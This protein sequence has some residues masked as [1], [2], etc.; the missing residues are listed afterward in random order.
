MEAGITDHIWTIR[1]LLSY[2]RTRYVYPSSVGSMSQHNT[3]PTKCPVCGSTSLQWSERKSV[4]LPDDRSQSNIQ[5]VLSYRC[6]NGH[7][8]LGCDAA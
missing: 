4:A 8:F 7:V 3:P 2:E 6:E 5:G 1:E